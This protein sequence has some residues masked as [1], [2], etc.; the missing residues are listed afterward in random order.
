MN[1]KRIWIFTGVAAVVVVL[2]L[3]KTG[4]FTSSTKAP[5][6]R[7]GGEMMEVRAVVVQQETMGGKVTTVGTVLANEEVEVR[8]EVSGKIERISFKEGGR[9][10][11]GDLLVKINDAELQ[12]QLARAQQRQTLAEQQEERQRQL[13]EKNL[14]SKEEFDNAV[15]NLNIAKAE[16]QLVKAQIDKTE[17]KAPFDGTLGLRFV[18]EGSYIS[19]QTV[20]TTLQ[21][22]STVKI[23][24]SVPE[25]YAREVRVG[26]KITFTTETSRHPLTATV[27]A[28]EPRIDERTRTLRMRALRANT[29]RAL[30]PGAFTSI[31]V[32]FK[33]RRTLMIPSFALVPE[34]KGQKVFLYSDGRAEAR[35]VEIGVRTE[36]RVEITE[37]LSAGDTLILSGILQLRP[38]M[39]VRVALQDKPPERRP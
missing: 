37:G 15:T 33:E 6:S 5:T 8:S 7:S 30:L 23:D 17:I 3:P 22:N 26:D 34:L 9:V 32:T 25:R 28:I 27:Y 10:R 20:I 11:K 31:E 14:T 4:L 39:P 13:Y 12:A 35:S 16:V 36:D 1:K 24:F 38:G 21:D 19:P 29:D 2:T 18:S